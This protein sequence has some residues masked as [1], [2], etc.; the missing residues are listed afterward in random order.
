[1]EAVILPAREFQAL[2]AAELPE[3]HFA[4][5]V[6]NGTTHWFPCS[7][8]EH[9]R[10]SAAPCYRAYF[11]HQGKWLFFFTEG[12]PLPFGSEVSFSKS[13]D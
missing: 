3:K 11:H 6:L 10:H 7:G 13:F 2:S 12:A 8:E 5:A 9:C 1:M 4:H